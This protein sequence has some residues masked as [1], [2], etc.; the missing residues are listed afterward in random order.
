MERLHAPC[1]ATLSCMHVYLAMQDWGTYDRGRKEDT[2]RIWNRWLKFVVL[3]V[4]VMVC[5]RA[6]LRSVD[7]TTLVFEVSSCMHE[8]LHW[9]SSVV[10]GGIGGIDP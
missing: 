6:T 10:S 1:M 4:T 3:M 5:K 8:C 7:T 9:S 2:V